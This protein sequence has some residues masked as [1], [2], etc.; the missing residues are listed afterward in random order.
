MTEPPPPP[1]RRGAVASF[2]AA[3]TDLATPSA[4]RQKAT[5]SVSTYGKKPGCSSSEEA[6]S[7]ATSG[8]ILP[9]RTCFKPWPARSLYS[10]ITTAVP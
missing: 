2:P 1:S 4:L 7:S 6:P 3:P 10:A 5:P 9:R 8:L